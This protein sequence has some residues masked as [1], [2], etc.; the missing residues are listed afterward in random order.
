MKKLVVLTLACAAIPVAFAIAQPRA[1]KS[2][3]P[4]SPLAG[5]PFRP[6]LDDP[7]AAEWRTVDPENLLVI[8]T[9]KGRILVEMIPELAPKTVA[10][11]KALARQHFY[12]GLTFHRV[13]D[14]FMAQGGDPKGDGTGGSTLPDVPGEFTFRHGPQAPYARIA[15]A[16]GTETGFVKSAPVAGQSSDL[17]AL[18]VDGKVNGY[19]RFCKNSAGF[20]R[21]GSPDSGNSQ[22]FLMRANRPDLDQMYTVWGRVLSGGD[23]VRAL[24]VGEPPADPD[25]MTSVRVAADL[26]AGQQP[27]VQVVDPA[28]AWMTNAAKYNDD[29]CNIDLPVKVTN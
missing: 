9:T 14:D 13:I 26:P 17:A 4:P 27:K 12:D 23:V 10:Q 2:K 21:A 15:G 3:T 8:D 29:L 25:K 7:T 22:F 19:A 18:T 28:S 6:K 16:N 24:K 20:A 1:S 11:I 5:Q